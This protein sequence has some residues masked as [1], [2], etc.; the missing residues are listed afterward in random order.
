V[1][2]P[3]R[4]RS[5]LVAELL[6]MRDRSA[7]LAQ[8]GP[9]R[10][11]EG[12]GQDRDRALLES[13]H[14][15]L[16]EL[17]ERGRP[18]YVSPT[19]EDILGYAPE[20][21]LGR[22][23]FDWLHED[24]L[25]ALAEQYRDA[26]SSGEALKTTY[27]AR[28]KRGHWVWLESTASSY[29]LLDG[30]VRTVAFTRDVTDVKTAGAA[31]RESEDRLAAILAN[32]SELVS[33]LDAEGRFL[34]VSPNCERILGVPA[35]AIVGRRLSDIEAPGAVHPD[36]RDALVSGYASR[37]ATGGRGQIELRLRHADG[38]WHW[39]EGR[40][41][42]YRTQD[43]AL[44]AVVITCDISDRKRV[45]EELRESNERYRV[46]AETSG[47]LIA[48][49]DPDGRLVYVSPTCQ[50][51]LGYAPSE[52]VG[53]TPFGLLHPEDVERCVESFLAGIASGQPER[54][55]P[56]R[57]RHKD[58]GWRWCEGTGVTY[59]RADGSV[60]FLSALRDV[61]ERRRA[62][63]E[64]RRF[65]DHMQQ[66]QKLESLGVLAGGIAHDF[67]NL[68]TP[69]LG[70]AS[71][72]LEDLPE[73]SPA[74]AR[75]LKIRRAAQRAAALTRQ[76]LAYTGQ[77]SLHR[78]PLDLSHVV[79]DMAQL[80][81]SAV[82]RK[83]VLVYDLAPDL[84]AVEADASQIGQIA[85]NLI[86]NAA[87]AVN[88]TGRE[89]RIELRTGS[90]DV[91]AGASL[92]SGPLEPGRYVFFEVADTGCGMDADTRSRIFDPFFT[93]KFTGRGLGLA[94]VLG[95][96]RAHRGGIAVDSEPG[97]GTR[98]RVL[99]PRSPRPRPSGAEP[100]SCGVEWRTRGTVL[101]VDDDEGVRD[102][103]RE[104]L[105]RCGLSVL[106]AADG[107]E[108]LRLFRARADEIRAVLLDRTMP[109]TSAEAVF[110]AM[111]EIRPE[112]RIVLASGY[113]RAS[114]ADHFAGRGAAGF[115]QKPFLPETLIEKLREVL[116]E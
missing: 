29:R 115:L 25:P 12:A 6:A 70:D 112:A 10:A 54:T 94:A 40:G 87:E 67:N 98:F 1:S 13:L 59:R 5:E 106:C 89:G 24:D 116:G 96:V 43:G 68:L 19:V 61:T 105:R 63:E 62:E 37:I 23:G 93:T 99:L 58:G 39:F 38:T 36:D 74:R 28:H 86:T 35:A 65:E 71:L 64:R 92:T 41:S 66:A 22:P 3:R 101:V 103:T 48:E 75:L 7:P 113:S 53:T 83:A 55:E 69:I 18:I 15:M 78:E 47:D 109:A 108:A 42:S 100:P 90:V 102:L 50:R 33:E 77:E 82:S 17:D 81:E 8:D 46:V 56:F 80:L 9:R 52:V 30:S 34:Y 11:D 49:S 91:E 60:R 79:R 110:D 2:A 72:A 32:A 26:A 14:A 21:I 111:R 51:V 16:I 97:K 44:R 27:R 76:M 45:Q 73:D 4:T 95:I 20:E 88:E 104:T 107:E 114:T 85:M 31:L 84:P 57:V